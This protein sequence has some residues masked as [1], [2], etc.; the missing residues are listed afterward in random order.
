M[1]LGW[2]LRKG[3]QLGKVI[4]MRYPGTSMSLRKIKM[5]IRVGIGTDMGTG[6]R[7]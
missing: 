1:G 3:S 2:G 5:G 6:M 4:G 7:R